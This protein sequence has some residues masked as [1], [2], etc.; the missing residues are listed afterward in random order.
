MDTSAGKHVLITFARSFLTLEL[1]RLMA[2]AGHQVT[3]VDSIPV[4]VSR[5]SNSTSK[6][7]RVPP[8]K[9]EPQA[10]CRKLSQI[11][12]D[13]GIDLVIPIHE[14]TDI[15]SMMVGL[16]DPSV[17]LF[18]TD[19]D[20][21]DSLHN[22]VAF[23]RKLDELGLPTLP[24]ASVANDAELAAVDLG[25]TYALKQSYSRGSQN[26][27]KV[28]PGE[29]LPTP[30]YEDGNE[31]LAQR[32]TSGTSYCTYSICHEG[33]IYAHATYPVRYAIDGKSCLTFEQT[34]H[35]GIFEWV[36]KIV[37]ETNFTGQI[38]FDFIDNPDDGLR[39]IE[40][41][42]RATSGIMM[43]RPHNHVDRAF[44]G[45]NVSESGEVELIEPDPDV[46]KMIGVGMLLYGWRKEAFPQNNWRGFAAEFR[47]AQDVITRKGDEKP[48]WMLVPSYTNI[49]RTC[50]KYKVG[51]AE[52]FMHDHEW[53]GHRYEV[54]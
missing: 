43:F 8:P 27:Y 41:N 24:F 46:D 31:W 49:L 40:C 1:S 38:G 32:W 12:V 18:L 30:V 53:D 26:I 44:F 3:V 48:A 52:A 10:Y 14:E 17:K 22:K 11:V 54:K 9:F 7:V 25:G 39:C 28:V 35:P 42:P 5:Y 21:L 15:L 45:T 50:W 23:Q 34:T 51:L 4:T 29:P 2:A 13:E 47:R 19:F 37:A 16:F 36:T 33:Q 6:F 20:M